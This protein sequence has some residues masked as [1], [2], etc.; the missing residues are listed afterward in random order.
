MIRLGMAPDQKFAE[1][2]KQ[3]R[4]D[5]EDIKNAQRIG[6]DILR[7]NIVQ[8]FDEAGNP[9][10]YDFVTELNEWGDGTIYNFTAVL[11]ADHQTEPWATPFYQIFYGAP[12]VPVEASQAVGVTYPSFTHT[13]PGKIAYKGY[14]LNYASPD[15]TP[16]YVKVYFY[17]TDTGKLTIL[18]GYID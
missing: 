13:V 9:T 7:P 10:P 1:D 18:P 3:L 8:C 11:E 6:S 14:V 12:G 4:R 5:I 16:I 2:F 17:A 15:T